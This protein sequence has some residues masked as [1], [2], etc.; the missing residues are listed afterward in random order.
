MGIRMGPSDPPHAP[1]WLQ[2]PDPPRVWLMAGE[3]RCDGDGMGE[4]CT[5]T[6]EHPGGTADKTPI[7]SPE[8]PH[9]WHG[10][11]GWSCT[12]CYHL[13]FVPGAV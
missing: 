9:S 13:P 11:A 7:P 10:E 4:G 12:S 3:A 1:G 8:S 2:S 6:P 5:T